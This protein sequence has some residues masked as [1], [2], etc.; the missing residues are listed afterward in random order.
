MRA[1]LI[2]Y[3]LLAGALNVVTVGCREATLSAPT[4]PTG[5]LT[6][7]ARSANGSYVARPE[8]LFAQAGSALSADSRSTVDTCRV[9][10][11]IPQ[12]TNI[13]LDQI[14]AGDSIVFAAGSETTALR[15]VKRFGITVYA[16]EPP[17]VDIVPGTEVSFT[18][19]GAVGGF[20]A[21]TIS[22]LTPPALT[23]LA[24]IPARPSPDQPLEVTWEPVGDD[25]SR[26]EALLIYAR[27][28]TI[29]FNEQVVCEWRDD[30][31]GTIRPELLAGWALSELQRIEVSRYRTQRRE[32]ADTVLFLLATFDTVPPVVP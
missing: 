19:P 6:L 10:D 14:D 1:S 15:P 7:F 23:A 31:S 21:T 16:A 11:Y 3:L 25:S 13:I 29:N 4:I 5:V 30:G 20:P 28:G 17:E 18:I 27:Q 24:P 8:A 22:S 26:F 32:I 12:S 9:G 2:R